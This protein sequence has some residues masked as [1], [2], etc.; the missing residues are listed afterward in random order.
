MPCA[1]ADPVC[2]QL[3]MLV[4]VC[5]CAGSTVHHHVRPALRLRWSAAMLSLRGGDGDQG[6]DDYA[7]QPHAPP[8]VYG[9]YGGGAGTGYGGYESYGQGYGQYE[10]GRTGQEDGSSGYGGYGGDWRGRGR[11]GRGRAW[12]RGGR[13]RFYSRG[14]GG[15]VG[16][17]VDDSAGAE[18]LHGGYGSYY[19][20]VGGRGRYRSRWML[21]AVPF[22]L[23][24]RLLG[25]L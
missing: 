3:S 18:V 7:E 1:L 4:C 12:E 2:A 21:V 11:G 15:G 9:Q 14:A 22:S 16:A 25:C 17:W 8:A 20:G 19:R 5:A 23:P 13:G 6:G 24:C 10:E